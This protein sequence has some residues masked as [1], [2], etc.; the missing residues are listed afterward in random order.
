M[1]LKNEE[2]KLRETLGQVIHLADELVI[3]VD[4]T[5][6]DRTYEIAKSYADRVPKMEV[7]RYKWQDDFSKM[8]NECFQKATSDWVMMLD[9]HD[10]I[11]PQSQPILSKI[12][13]DGVD[14]KV[15]VI[16]GIMQDPPSGSGVS[17]YTRPVLFRRVNGEGKL[18]GKDGTHWEA[19]IHNYIMVDQ[20]RKILARDLVLEH[21]QPPERQ[22]ARKS[23]RKVM[24]TQGLEDKLKLNPED[25]RSMFYLAR[26]YDEMGE[27]DKA[28]VW[29]E[30]HIEHCKFP[31][32]RYQ[33]RV[34]LAM[35]YWGYFERSRDM[36]K[37]EKARETLK[38]C[39]LDSIP[40]NDHCILLGDMALALERYPEA[41]YWFRL[42]AAYKE[43][44]IFLF[45]NRSTYTW[46]PH[47]RLA[48]ACGYSSF[49]EEG[50][51]A[52]RKALEFKPTEKKYYDVAN[53]LQHQLELRKAA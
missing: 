2:V 23:Q 47:E 6:S 4:E 11:F 19:P 28:S 49:F 38:G 46:M 5:S 24:N 34:Q 39:W 33:S 45:I 14:E 40:R 41:V 15:D 3:G 44:K 8:R 10:F 13:N 50:L 43:P 25:A 29:F 12:A 22:Q 18:L 9:G 32:E 48:I 27:Y 35:I 42:A 26:T 21:R 37:A 52:I 31:D 51:S 20:K 36:E 7:Y 1:C 17:A 16:D 53:K 30:K